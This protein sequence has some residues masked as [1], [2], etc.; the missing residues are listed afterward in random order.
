MQDDQTPAGPHPGRRVLD[1]ASGR[2]ATALLLADGYGCQVDGVDYAPANTAL[3]RG[4]AVAAG[5]AERAVF[6]TG[7]AERLPFPDGVFDAVVCECALCTFPDKA[8]AAAEFA[9]VL[10]PGGRVGITDVTAVPGRL[11]PELTGLTA[12]I[13]CVADARSLD[14]YV[15][16]LAAAGLRTLRTER[17][18]QDMTRVIDQIG[19]RLDLLRLTAATAFAD[20]TR[21]KAPEALAAAR[22]AVADGVLGYALSS[23][24]R[25][26]TPPCYRPASPK[27]SRTAP[28]SPSPGRRSPTRNRPSEPAC[29]APPPSS[30]PAPTPSPHRPSPPP[31]PA[32][33]PH[34]PRHRLARRH[35]GEPV[36]GRK[37]NLPAATAVLRTARELR[38]SCAA[39]MFELTTN[40]RIIT[41]P[42]QYLTNRPNN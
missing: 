41:R 3:A 34:P 13:A 17:H 25:S 5:L 31:S 8:R 42:D 37:G 14:E 39:S 27:P 26:P 7:D 28:T 15:G 12:R 19:A 24:P 23:S 29:T 1:V 9:R 38:P 2:G 36:L 22:R 18:D 30:S 4:A 6:A 32:V 35:L 40:V 21:D 16:I 20:L 33:S 10:R 11:P